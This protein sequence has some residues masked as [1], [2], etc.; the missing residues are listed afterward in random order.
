LLATIWLLLLPWLPAAVAEWRWHAPGMMVGVATLLA[1]G[2]ARLRTPSAIAAALA[3][4]ERFRLRE[5]A[6][7]ALTLRDVERRTPAAQ[8]LMADAEKYVAPLR[9]GQ[10]FRLR[11]G[12]S[13][14]VV[15]AAALL[16]LLTAWLY[17]P[18]PADA[19]ARRAEEQKPPPDPKLEAALDQKQKEMLA[20]AAAK[21]RDEPQNKEQKAQ[22]DQFDK[23]AHMPHQTPEEKEDLAKAAAALEDQLKERDKHLAEQ[24]EALKE[25]WKR[26][27]RL[28]KKA[29]D[30]KGPGAGVEKALQQG[31][32]RKAEDE[33]KRLGKQVQEEEDA[34][35]KRQ[36]KLA[37]DKLDKE[38]REKLDREQQEAAQR[39]KQLDEQLKDLQERAE[40]L[41]D[42][43]Q[44]VKEIEQAVKEGKLDADDAERE[45]E[46]LEEAKLDELAR[47]DLK[48][49]AEKLGQCQ[50]CLKEGED[51]E[52]AKKLQEAAAKCA[53]L[54]GQAE[55][56]ELG[57]RVKQL[58]EARRACNQA[59]AKRGGDGPN[60][61]GPG[62]G[63][64]AEKKDGETDKEEKRAPG[65]LDDGQK[66]VVDFVPAPGLKEAPNAQQLQEQV[67]RAAQE[68]P[69]AIERGRL[70]AGEAAVTRGF[71]EKMRGAAKQK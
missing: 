67:Q 24:A 21:K 56:K 6:V 31:D 18:R 37:D 65:N 28:A 71:F 12:W 36:E 60:P 43:Q 17:D 38:E 35:K 46:R 54:D 41:A 45:K 58:Q 4:D 1:L 39:K 23:V 32:L 61:G 62:A 34:E 57:E 9:I 51:G 26:E 48:D 8:A 69:D 13:A 63:R 11:L 59:L 50:K 19:G 53:K 7:T 10:R 64:R 42:P 15:P 33:L 30:P 16:L 70:N 66:Q 27:D 55:R 47:Q 14:V 3:L 68:A 49:L 52:A 40:R 22:N 29:R 44:V 25:Q 5:R 2:V 20:Q